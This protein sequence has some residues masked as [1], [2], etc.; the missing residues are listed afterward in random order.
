M[1]FTRV[2]HEQGQERQLMCVCVWGA[3]DL[4]EFTGDMGFDSRWA[5]LILSA[6]YISKTNSFL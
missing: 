2:N 1:L 5:G 3:C 4:C 6:P